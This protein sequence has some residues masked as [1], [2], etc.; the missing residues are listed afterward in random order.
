MITNIKHEHQHEN[1][2]YSNNNNNNN[3]HITSWTVCGNIVWCFVQVCGSPTDPHGTGGGNFCA[4]L[5]VTGVLKPA[6]GPWCGNFL[7]RR[8]EG[9]LLIIMQR[10]QSRSSG[11]GTEYSTRY[12]TV[13]KKKVH[14]QNALLLVLDTGQVHHYYV[15]SFRGSRHTRQGESLWSCILYTVYCKIIL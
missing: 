14:K 9:L 12:G 7:E 2:Q 1:Q 8:N 4:G 6:S 5:G 15:S 10:H 11:G 13:P 3:T